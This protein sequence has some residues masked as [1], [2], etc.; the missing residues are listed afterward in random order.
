MEVKRLNP[1]SRKPLCV[2][3]VVDNEAGHAIEE[4]MLQWLLRNYN[5]IEVLHDGTKFEYPALSYMQKLCKETGK[6][7]LYIH[8]RG[9]FHRW[10]T[11]KPTH[12]MWRHEFGSRRA[13][14]FGVVSTAGPTVACPFTGNEDHTWYNGFVANA[15]AMEAIGELHLFTDRMF[16]EHMFRNKGVQVIGLLVNCK[17][18]NGLRDAR[19]YLK[20]HFA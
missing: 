14:Y 9:A 17:N 5:V 15:Q 10:N 8:T 12:R 3:G 16:Y 20:E 6:P 19:Q 1:Q 2:F 13:D 7:C 11:T 4:E 18:D